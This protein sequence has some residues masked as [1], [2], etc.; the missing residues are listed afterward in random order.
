M[1]GRT[2]GQ[3]DGQAGSTLDAAIG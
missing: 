3:T 1:D 2:V